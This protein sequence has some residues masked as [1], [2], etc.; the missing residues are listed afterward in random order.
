MVATVI[1]FFLIF[2]I[3]VISHEFGHFIIGKKSGIRVNEFSVGMGP[4]LLHFQKGETRYTLRAFPFGGA[5]MFDGEDMGGDTDEDG[6]NKAYD[7]HSFQNVNVWRRIATVIAGPAANY[8]VAIVCALI[9]VAFSGSDR[10]V[11]QK[12]MPDSAAQEAGMQ[13]GDTITR[14]NGEHIHLYREVSLDSAM[15]S[16][17]DPMNV[18]YERGGKK[19]EVTLVPKYSKKDARYYIG[20]VG[21]GDYFRCNAPQV[22]QYSFYEVNYWTK[23]TFKSLRMLITGKVGMNSLSGPVGIAQFVGDTYEEVKPYGISSVIFTMMDILIL[24]SV[25]LAIMNLL[26][27]PALDGGRL[28]FMIIEVIRGKRVPPEKEGMV[29]LAGFV[30]LMLLM[31]FVMYQDIMRLIG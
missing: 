15:N 31:V 6:E 11:V 23:Y 18:T 3:L 28:L 24:L 17:G 21:G 19:Y 20:L 1:L 27:L 9:V 8:I 2:G 10:P 13:A 29:H 30:A 22:F 12:V 7:E 5:C 14:I 4:V 25:N 16:D 26:P